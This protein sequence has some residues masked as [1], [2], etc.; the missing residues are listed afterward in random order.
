MSELLP[1]LLFSFA[2]GLVCG[3]LS[4]SPLGSINLWIIARIL[5]D[6][7]QSTRII[8]YLMGVVSADLTYAV[9]AAWGYRALFSDTAAEAWIAGLGGS[10]LILLGIFA[11]RRHPD[12]SPGDLAGK[13]A[14]PARQWLLGIFMCGSNPGFL[15][16][17][18]FAI[19]QLENHF[20]GAFSDQTL[21]FFLA[22]IAAG[23]LL[24]F[25][26][27]IA[28]VR[29]FRNMV[30]EKFTQVVNRAVAAAFIVIGTISIIKI[31]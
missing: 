23:D 28:G 25:G 11:W 12:E 7:R 6:V 2:A 31:L 24:W 9:L 22:G 1:S 5:N 21:W 8:W 13:A 27:L 26:L 20:A 3:F 16:F 30:S 18:I 29:R 4:S 15:L 17:W 19:D 10:F 14:S